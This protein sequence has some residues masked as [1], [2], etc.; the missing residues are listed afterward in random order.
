[1]FIS[2][3]LSICIFHTSSL[4]FSGF[5]HDGY[6]QWQDWHKSGTDLSTF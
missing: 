5:T 2:C 4:F 1:V 3:W 6:S